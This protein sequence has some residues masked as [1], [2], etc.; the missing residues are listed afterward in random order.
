MSRILVVQGHPDAAGGHLCHALAEAYAAAALAA[1]HLV[2]TVTPAALAFPLLA[3]AHEWEH[4]EVPPAL[5]P[6]QQAVAAAQ[7]IVI[8]YPLWLGDMPAVLKGFLEQAMRPGFA[9]QRK[10]GNPLR[11]G[12]LG[13]RSARVVVTMGMPALFYRWYFRAHSLKSLER[14]ILNFVGITPVRSTLVGGAGKMDAAAVQ[15][16]CRRMQVLGAK[17]S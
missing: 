3:N 14:N 15:G 8:F 12:L 13:G 10:A 1:G 6:A 2:D 4:G 16:W 9:L 5:L 17:G 7:H 11:A